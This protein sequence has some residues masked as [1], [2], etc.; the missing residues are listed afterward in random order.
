MHITFRFSILIIL[1]STL[2]ISCED[3]KED[4]TEVV[5]NSERIYA[6]DISSYPELN[7]ASTVFYDLAGNASSLL[8]L[9]AESGVNTIRLRLWVNPSN[10]HSSLSEVTAFSQILKSKG[11]K[12]WLTLHYSDT[13][14]DPGNQT[15]P[16]AWES[17]TLS[18]LVSTVY[19]YTTVVVNAIDPEYI[20]IGN[21]INSGI[22]HPVG[23]LNNG[24]DS[25]LQLMT[26]GI[27]AVR[28]YNPTTKIIIH[29]A[30]IE[31]SP[32]FY[33]QL[34][35]LDYDVIGLS[36]YP[37]WH[38]KSLLDVESQLKFLAS[39]HNKEVII[40]ETAYPFTL[41]FNDYTN[42]IVGLNSQLI[43]P[44][45]PA[46]P[47]GQKNF[48]QKIKTISTGFEAGLGFCYWG[49]ELV[50]W[51]GE[52]ATDASPWENQA[53]F[54]FDNQALPALDVFGD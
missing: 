9:L 26:A 3:D 20:Q 7:E 51:K 49:A 38:G 40:A 11:F 24:N 36:Y 23:N 21:E 19:N 46:T 15:I 12:I 33:D 43:T 22:M 4:Q 52:Q 1:I 8:D 28:D 17:Q 34:D 42:N 10:S 44:L 45:Y 27:D 6:V 29:F 32:W 50:A 53:L 5:Q 41:D 31:G 54:D 39:S 47:I 16:S 14:A 2:F 30:G 18:E 48:L 25:F 37:I 35:T 13:W